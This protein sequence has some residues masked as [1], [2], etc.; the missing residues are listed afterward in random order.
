MKLHDQSQSQL[1]APH[2]LRHL[3]EGAP[4]VEAPLSERLTLRLNFSV[5]P[6]ASQ[7]R[8]TGLTRA[9]RIKLRALERI[10]CAL[11]TRSRGRTA[12]RDSIAIAHTSLI[13]ERWELA[14]VITSFACSGE[15][16]LLA[17]RKACRV[18]R[19]IGVAGLSPDC[20]ACL[21][22]GLLAHLELG[23]HSLFVQSKL[24]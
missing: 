15:V 22:L 1:Y 9:L 14:E 13:A 12:R 19:W 21:L 7:L 10:P 18:W 4:L 23:A 24:A 8:K 3:D 11:E 16:H 6:V 17:Q 5:R 20:E 2:A